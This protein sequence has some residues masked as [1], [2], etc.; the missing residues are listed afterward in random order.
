MLRLERKIGQ[1]VMIDKG[2]I[3]VK[4]LRVFGEKVTLGFFADKEIIIDT[5]E[6]HLQSVNKSSQSSEK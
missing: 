3:L 4:V 1:Q 2:R 5:E 6:R